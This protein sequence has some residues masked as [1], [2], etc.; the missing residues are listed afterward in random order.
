MQ[1]LP[2]TAE[3]WLHFTLVTTVH[4]TSCSYLLWTAETRL[5]FTPVSTLQ[6]TS[7]SYL[8]GTAAPWLHFAPVTTVNCASVSYTHL[9]VYK[10]QTFHGLY[11]CTAIEFTFLL[12]IWLACCF[13]LNVLFQTIEY[14]TQKLIY[15]DVYKRQ[16]MS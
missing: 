12:G 13:V 10:R 5:H 8:Q 6:C 2:G 7:C 3:P 1:L 16:H 9:D 4:C 15:L 14:V 11:I